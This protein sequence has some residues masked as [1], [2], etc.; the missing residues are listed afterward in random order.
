M[1]TTSGER[2]HLANVGW[3]YEGVG[4]Y[5]PVSGNPVYRVYNPNAG[6]HHYTMNAVEMYSL[7]M[8][9]WRYE[10]IGFYSDPNQAVPLFRA[11][12][13]NAQAGSH[14]YTTDRGENDHL[15]RLGWNNEGI[16]WY[17]IN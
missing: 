4:W 6:D 1:Y 14:N 5:A 9:E 3:N 12:N 10:G 15:C 11:Y 2:D 16:A 13:P 8:A 7:V 17:G